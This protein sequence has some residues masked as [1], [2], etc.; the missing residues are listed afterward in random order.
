MSKEKNDAIAKLYDDKKEDLNL[1][2]SGQDQLVHH[3]NG[4]CDPNEVFPDDLPQEELLKLLHTQET[5]L[6]QLG[7]DYLD[8]VDGSAIG[9]DA[10][11]GRGGSAILINKQ[12]DCSVLGLSL[13]S[14]QVA[15]ASDLVKKMD[16]QD[17]I[18]F[19]IGDM[20][21][22]R[23]GNKFFNFIW[24]CESTEHVDD[25]SKMFKEFYRIAKP[26]APL[27]II[28]WTKVE[29]VPDEEIV[30]KVNDAYVTNI[31][32]VSEYEEAALNNGWT[33]KNKVDLREETASYWKLR[34]KSTVQSG[35]EPFMSKGFNSGVLGYY[36]LKFTRAS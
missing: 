8:K 24:A 31:H 4:I 13:S 12:F 34:E 19:E 28:T 21:S 32:F 36:L 15:F 5:N 10:G 3:H 6:V 25:L 1:V 23:F 16:L 29:T 20:N 7:I 27:L 18:S 14:Y 22:T 2:L 17:K 30:K 11:S 33:L 9:L 35:T 26:H